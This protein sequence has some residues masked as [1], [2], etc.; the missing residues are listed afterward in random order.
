MILFVRG[1]EKVIMKSGMS[2]C[3]PASREALL[4]TVG[5]PYPPG[6]KI[7]CISM[8]GRDKKHS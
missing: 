4:E 8:G 3:Y 1:H 2:G 7:V 5:F 6:N